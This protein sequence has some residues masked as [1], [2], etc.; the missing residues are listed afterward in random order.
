MARSTGW[1]ERAEEH[2]G[3]AHRSRAEE[4]SDSLNRLRHRTQG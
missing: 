3:E 1:D 4:L 2:A